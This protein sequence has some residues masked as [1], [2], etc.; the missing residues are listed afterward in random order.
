MGMAAPYGDASQNKMISVLGE[1]ERSIVYWSARMLSDSMLEGTH[2][3]VRSMA[4]KSNLFLDGEWIPLSILSRIKPLKALVKTPDEIVRLLTTVGFKIFEAVPDL[5][6]IRRTGS[7][8]TVDLVDSFM[9]ALGY[10]TAIARIH[11]S[12]VVDLAQ[13]AGYF[14]E[15]VRIFSMDCQDSTSGDSAFE[16]EFSNLKSLISSICTTREHKGLRVLVYPKINIDPDESEHSSQRSGKACSRFTPKLANVEKNRWIK[17]SVPPCAV[18]LTVTPHLYIEKLSKIA[19]LALLVLPPASTYG[20]ALFRGPVAAEA[21]GIINSTGGIEI[22]NEYSRAYV[23]DEFEDLIAW[24][25]KRGSP[26]IPYVYK[27]P[28]IP[29]LAH[30]SSGTSGSKK[31]RSRNLRRSNSKVAGGRSSASCRDSKIEN[32]IGPICDSTGAKIALLLNRMKIA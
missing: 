11:S 10:T 29:A 12:D 30:K 27:V 22:Y 19:S 26:S 3:T 18:D 13:M 21:V 16:V 14:P 20:L 2:N 9:R 5:S 31:K 15:D 4:K 23:L 24:E 7:F 6:S 8:T 32:D 17:F 28:K 1:R 25:I